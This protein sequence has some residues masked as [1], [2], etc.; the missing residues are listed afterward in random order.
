[1]GQEDTPLEVL[2]GNRLK[3]LRRTVGT[4]ESCTGGLIAHLLTEVPGSSAYVIGAVV[5]YSNSTKEQMLGVPAG[6]LI[7][8]GAV[9]EPVA[10]AMAEGAR[11]VLRVDYAVSVT[12]V[13]G[14][15]GGTPEKPVGLVYMAVASP[16]GT[17]PAVFNWESSDRSSNK[18]RSAQAALQLLLDRLG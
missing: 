18:Q 5:A 2:V 11:R 3:A 15:G 6:L 12:G 1:M 14:P 17:Y 7:Q 13:A 9:S 4:A 16:S 8:H 10:I